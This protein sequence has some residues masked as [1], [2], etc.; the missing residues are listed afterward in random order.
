L[1][2]TG[3]RAL[4]DPWSPAEPEWLDFNILSR[5]LIIPGDW[6]VLV[7]RRRVV[8]AGNFAFVRDDARTNAAR[9]AY[10]AFGP[11]R[12]HVA[13]I[14]AAAGYLDPDLPN[15]IAWGNFKKDVTDPVNNPPFVSTWNRVLF[16]SIGDYVGV[17]S[18]E[19][20]VPRAEWRAA[21]DTTL[22]TLESLS[23]DGYH[24]LTPIGV[25]FSGK[26]RHLFAPQVGRETCS[27]EVGCLVGIASPLHPGKSSW[28][29]I[30]HIL[31]TVETAL[32]QHH[33]G[34]PHWGQRFFSSQATLQAAYPAGT[35][36]KW[37][38]QRNK[39]DPA[40]LFDNA[41]STQMGL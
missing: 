35:W 15:G 31:A 37:K 38:T 5:R 28:S 34:R 36:A 19:I 41:F 26:S 11:N 2:P 24:S 33:Q 29:L 23:K 39:A 10:N 13:T 16:T 21:V 32:V 7:T 4:V 9:T 40:R 27:I 20:C 12:N 6:G 22:A 14:L 25:R 18:T 3:A 1:G 8:P 30:D 17:S